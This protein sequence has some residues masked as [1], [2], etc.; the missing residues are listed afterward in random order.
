MALVVR[1][2]APKVAMTL[3][4]QIAT[5][6]RQVRKVVNRIMPG[7]NA[8]VESRTSHDLET[9]T[10]T[11]ITTITFPQDPDG[12]SLLGTALHSLAD[13]GMT[14]ADCSIVIVRKR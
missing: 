4:L 9:D 3:P 8:T 10:P 6:S 13:K 1:S 11:M 7:V 5:A 14:V 12:A 2:R